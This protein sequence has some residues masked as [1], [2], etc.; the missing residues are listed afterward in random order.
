[1]EK[2]NSIYIVDDDPII[3]FGMR[4]ILDNIVE[5]ENISTFGNGML[6]LESIIETLEKDVEVPEIIFLD[7]N[8]P[9][10]DGWQ[11]LQEFIKLPLE[12]KVR[13]NIITSS[14]DSADR[15]TW[16]FYKTKTHHLIT[17]V[18]KPVRSEELIKITKPA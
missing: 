7:L 2:I 1:M 18:N 17:F 11:F 13:I 4:K 15:E 6:A 5:C 14:I 3:V 8:M 16:E 10:L 9:I 12:K